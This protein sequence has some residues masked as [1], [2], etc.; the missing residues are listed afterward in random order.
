MGDRVVVDASVAM[1]MLIAEEKSGAARD[2]FA[3]WS[4]A[5]SDLLVPSHFWVE[6]ANSLVRRH[7]R[8]ADQV[9][10]GLVVLDELAMRTIDLDR[11]TLLLAL[12]R[13]VAFRLSAYGA[14]YLALATAADAQLATLDRR[15]AE[16]AGGRGL[17][18]GDSE[19]HRMAET[20]AAYDSAVAASPAWAYSASVG[21]HIADLRRRTMAGRA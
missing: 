6:V 1:A 9:M 20:S 2:T 12:D 10:V 11:P 15:L 14:V 8:S 3:A 4:R 19:P 21:T 16:A 7:A 18:I 13:M 17:L 5:G